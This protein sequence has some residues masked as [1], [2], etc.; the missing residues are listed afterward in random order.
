MRGDTWA[1]DGTWIHHG[2]P[3]K[4]YHMGISRVLP[5]TKVLKEMTEK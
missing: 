3:R 5:T 2:E 1:L 4:G